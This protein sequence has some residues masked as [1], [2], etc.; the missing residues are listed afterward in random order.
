MV[1]LMKNK[2]GW[3]NIRRNGRYWKSVFLLILV[4]F[5]VAEYFRFKR[6]PIIGD[7]VGKMEHWYRRF[8]FHII[9]P[10]VQ[11]VFLSYLS[12]VL[13]FMLIIY[14]FNYLCGFFP[15]SKK[16]EKNGTYRY[17]LK[18][19]VVSDI[20]AGI[21]L[22][23]L[24]INGLKVLGNYLKINSI[25][26]GV[27][28]LFFI[29]GSYWYWYSILDIKKTKNIKN[30]LKRKEDY[31]KEIWY[32]ITNG[33]E[34]ISSFS[35]VPWY[36]KNRYLV[37][38]EVD[39]ISLDN[40]EKENFLKYLVVLDVNNPL[41]KKKE[42]IIRKIALLPHSLI[43]VVILGDANRFPELISF[44]SSIKNVYITE[45]VMVEDIGKI[46]IQ[47]FFD[48]YQINKK[49]KEHP[50][51][52]SSNKIY[53]TTYINMAN[54][55]M[56][57]AAFMKMTTV[58]LDIL[59]AIYALFDF[60]DLQYRLC[61]ACIIDS[62][63]SKQIAWMK[64][65]GRVIGNIGIMAGMIEDKLLINKG[66]RLSDALSYQEL[67]DEIIVEKDLELI[68]K[69]LANYEKDLTRPIWETIIYLT[70]SL[71]NV[72]R[73][74]GTFDKADAY[75]LYNLVFKLTILNVYIL[76][77]TDIQLEAGNDI[78]SVNG[79]DKYYYVYGGFKME[80]KRN[81]SPFLLSNGN[82]NILVFNNWNKSKTDNDIGNL[83]YINYL[84]GRL[85]LPEYKQLELQIKHL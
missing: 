43:H 53:K 55:S 76:N 38:D 78:L 19:V 72:L 79:N 30:K 26:F 23:I 13:L 2:K 68:R 20:F 5:N 61:I 42:N 45:D 27:Y 10:I 62:D 31:E 51:R 17:L 66:D 24:S 82:G 54:G 64:S 52:L 83:E 18:F 37:V 3:N 16:S 69:Y 40:V 47:C 9:K 67:F 85:I 28:I 36:R 49:Q 65:K 44:L 35:M 7:I 63:Y 46:N 6:M 77:S 39:I 34:R 75:E 4:L 80:A 1:N 8:P 15:N 71:R 11:Y 84:D 59:P 29:I 73:G 32:S 70:Y 74:H 14:T 58:S 60:I 50:L 81:L 12:L 56:L 21:V 25:A 41:D 22:E 48:N 57:C 33:N